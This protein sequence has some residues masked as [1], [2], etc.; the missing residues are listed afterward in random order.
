[1]P[2][3]AFDPSE[4]RDQAQAALDEALD[5]V[6]GETPPV[7]VERVVEQGSAAEVLCLESEFADLLVVGSRGRGAFAGAV[8]GSVSR[9]CLQHAS[10]PVAVVHVA[11]YG[12]PA[13]IV[14]GVDG[15]EGAA[16][17]LAWA[18]AEARMRGS[19]V[20]AVAAYHEPWGLSGGLVANPGAVLELRN[21]R[22]SRRLRDR[23]SCRRQSTRTCSSSDP[24]GA[25]GL[26]VSSSAR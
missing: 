19:A 23:R 16:A 26:Q 18:F 25:E 11:H 21:A 7:A 5:E 17:A 4:I 24:V 13:R 20:H 12:E 9:A 2:P 6:A 15:S 10:C 14:V 3:Q 1:M 22:P 8:L